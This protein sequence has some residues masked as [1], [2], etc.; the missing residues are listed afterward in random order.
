MLDDDAGRGSE[1]LHAFPRGVGVGDVVVRE[2]LALQLLVGGDGAGRWRRVTVKSSVLVRVFAV[3]QYFDAVKSQLQ[4]GWKDLRLVGI[5][6][7]GQ[8]VGN[9]RVVACRM[10]K[11]LFR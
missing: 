1:G 11:G 9:R 2:F 10:R 4:L 3:T 6:E 5:I 8:P 7:R